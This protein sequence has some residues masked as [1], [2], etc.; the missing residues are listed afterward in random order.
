ME[1][2]P[3]GGGTFEGGSSQSTAEVGYFGGPERLVGEEGANE[4]GD[5]GDEGGG[6]GT[7]SAVVEEGGG[8][9]QDPLMR[10]G[11]EDK[12]LVSIKLGREGAPALNEEAALSGW[13]RREEAGE[14]ALDGV[15]PHAAEGDQGK[16]LTLTKLLKLIGPRRRRVGGG[17]PE[18][19]A[20]S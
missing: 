16:L 13:F 17:A 2:L 18:V 20:V 4:L 5:P 10:G 12:D 3:D 7:G 19:T 8:V 1:A 14:I 6:G 11:W 15:S 9:G